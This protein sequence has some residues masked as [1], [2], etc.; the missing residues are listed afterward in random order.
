MTAKI[1]WAIEYDQVH[2][3]CITPCCGRLVRHGSCK[4]EHFEGHRTP[5]CGCKED[6]YVK[7]SDFTRKVNQVTYRG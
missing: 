7:K 4:G 1:A 2:V 3:T 6:Y 5:H